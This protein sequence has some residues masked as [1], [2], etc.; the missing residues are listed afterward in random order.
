MLSKALAH[1]G[2]SKTYVLLIIFMAMGLLAVIIAAAAF[3]KDLWEVWFD[4]AFVSTIGAVLR[5]IG[6]DGA[7]KVA[8][9][10]KNPDSAAANPPPAVTEEKGINAQPIIAAV[11]Q[12]TTAIVTNFDR[13]KTL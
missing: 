5:A 6:V 2:N 13:S 7:P 10:I 1:L 9:A 3:D 8:A 12:P 11:P 4:Q